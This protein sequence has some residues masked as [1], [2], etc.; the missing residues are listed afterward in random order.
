[1]ISKLVLLRWES[2]SNSYLSKQEKVK[3]DVAVTGLQAYLKMVIW[4]NLIHADLHPGNVLIRTEELCFFSRLA[5]YLLLGDSDRNAAHIVLLDAGLAAAFK[6]SLVSSIFGFFEAMTTFDGQTFGECI[7]GLNDEQPF[8]RDRQAFK[9]EV[10]VKMERMSTA[11]LE[12]NEGRAGDHIRDF[13]ASCR[14]HRLSLDPSVMVALMSM[15][16]LE[17]WQFRLDPEASVFGNVTSALGGGFFGWVNQA[18]DALRKTQ[19]AVQA[20]L[21]SREEGS[22]RKEVR[23]RK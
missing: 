17:G 12:R 11:M 8:V 5:R 21:T 22:E 23:G 18:G 4:D 7:L 15:M 16:V 19:R 14:A 3:K 6:P 10:S 1:M 9:D 2:N 20:R 13:M